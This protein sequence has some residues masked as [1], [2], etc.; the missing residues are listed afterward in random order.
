MK[1]RDGL[2]PR[3]GQVAGQLAGQRG[4]RRSSGVAAA[5]SR[6]VSQLR[7][8]GDCGSGGL[9]RTGMRKNVKREQKRR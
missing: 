3:T 8:P 2:D 4:E 9:I 5:S 7:P 6:V 1:V